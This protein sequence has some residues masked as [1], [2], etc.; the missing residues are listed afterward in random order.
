MTIYHC[1]GTIWTILYVL[2]NI[3]Y[4]IHPWLSYFF[5]ESAN[6]CYYASSFYEKENDSIDD[7]RYLHFVSFWSTGDIKPAW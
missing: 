5:S 6:M 7:T 3:M 1:I 4:K 2:L